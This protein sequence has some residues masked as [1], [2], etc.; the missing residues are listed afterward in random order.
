[1]Q[2]PQPSIETQTSTSLMQKYG[3]LAAQFLRFGIV[4]VLNTG[5]DFA[6]L[7]ALSWATGITKGAEV[8][9]LKAVAFLAANINSYLLNKTWTFK[10]KTSGEGAKKFSIYVTVSIIGAL[11]NLGT[12][13]VITTYTTPMFGVSDKMWLNLANLVATAVSLIWNFV[14][15]KLIVFRGK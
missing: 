9:P 5:I 4:G 12:V 6:I 8:V 15:Y 11:L 13:Y 7:N 1:M 14:G 10:D 2:A 3:P